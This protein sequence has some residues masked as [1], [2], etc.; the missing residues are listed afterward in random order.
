MIYMDNAA[1]TKI[2][3]LV[4]Q[5]IKPYLTSYYGN[6]S[7]IH[8]LGVQSKKVINSARETIAGIINALPQEIF[9][10]SCGSESNNWALKGIVKLLL[11]KN[12][13]NIITT[14]FEHHSIL[15]TCKYLHTLGFTVT[16]ILM[17]PAACTASV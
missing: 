12:K 3:P 8:E 1:T 15:N 5:T 9:F 16:S 10:T 13:T 11:D 17:C 6:P 2:N 14:S 4:F 7:S